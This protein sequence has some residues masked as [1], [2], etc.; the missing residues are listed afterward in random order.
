MNLNKL[1]R[2]VRRE[3]RDNLAAGF[4][5]PTIIFSSIGE[6]TEKGYKKGLDSGT[7]THVIFKF[8]L[9]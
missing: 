6:E 1:G 8:G 7:D 9:V 3:D 5:V 4:G 2:S